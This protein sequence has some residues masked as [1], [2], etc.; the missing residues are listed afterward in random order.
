MFAVKGILVT[1]IFGAYHLPAKEA[2]KI[3][4][5]YIW[6]N[7]I[8]IMQETYRLHCLDRPKLEENVACMG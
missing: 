4:R 8:R 2:A 1:P 5:L 7:R 3:A 6:S